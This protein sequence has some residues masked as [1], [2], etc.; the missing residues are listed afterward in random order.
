MWPRLAKERHLATL[1]DECAELLKQRWQPT[2]KMP[3]E[4]QREEERQ[5]AMQKSLISYP[6]RNSPHSTT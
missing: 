6:R 5:S 3:E 1:H 4:M 2:D